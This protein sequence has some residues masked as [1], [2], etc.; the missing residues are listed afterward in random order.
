MTTTGEAGTAYLTV[1]EVAAEIRMSVDYVRRQ[2]ANGAIKAKKLGTEW[3]IT[4]AALAA[5]MGDG[6]KAPATR[7][8]L[9]ARQMRRAS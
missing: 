2:C 5:F 3:R 6:E 8:R 7:K 4:P 1:D 9:S